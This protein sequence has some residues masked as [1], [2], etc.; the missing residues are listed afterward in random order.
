MHQGVLQSGA[1]ALRYS[2]ITQHGLWCR[3]GSSEGVAIKRK[4]NISLAA[5]SVCLL[6]AA[7]GAFALTNASVYDLRTI[8]ATAT[9]NGAI[10]TQDISQPTG[11][12]YIDPFLRL[13]D[14]PIEEA[15]NTDYRS[16]GQAPLDAKSD[17]NYTHSLQLRDLA[18]VTKNNVDY[19][20]F[21]LDLDEP[22]AG[23]FR[24]LS[25]D[26]LRFYVAGSGNIATLADLTSQG[27]LK[28]DLDQGGNNTI[29]L[30]GA[31]SPGNGADDM[32]LYIPTSTFAGVDPSRYL[33][34]YSKFGA[35]AGMQAD[36][37]DA[38]ASFE[39]WSALRTNPPVAAEPGVLGLFG[40]GLLGM[41]ATR[42]RKER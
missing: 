16:N 26:E 23:P 14:S 3:T 41:L 27:T 28:W 20:C 39:E 1:F 2:E 29:Y 19:Y 30:D 38:N 40:A 24:Y 32:R 25:L 5:A 18:T 12:G 9:V 37:F 10:F 6:V 34:L 7:P 31:L 17:P 11:T 15:F 21:S 13:Q 35:T 8:G 33:Y 4:R 42:R 36:N 22:N